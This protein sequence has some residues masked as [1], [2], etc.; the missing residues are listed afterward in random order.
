MNIGFDG[1]GTKVKIAQMANNHRTIA[2]D[3]IA[4]VA[5]DAV[6]RGAEP[7]LV[8]TV[9]DVNSLGTS[10]KPFIEEVRQLSEGYINAAREAN[11][12][13]INGEVAEIG[14]CVGG[15]GPFNYNWGAGV[16]WFARKD[17][18][19]TGMEIKEGDYLVGLREKGFRSNGLSLVRKVMEK[20][21]GEDWYK[22]LY[23][24]RNESLA[25]LVLTPSKIY[26]KAAVDM[27]GG[28]AGEPRTEVHGIVHVTGGGIP[29]K[30][31]R[32]LKPSEL[33]ATIDSSFEPPEIMEYTQKIGGVT[34]FEAYKTWNMGPG[35]IIVT[36]KPEEVIKIAEEYDIE[37]KKIG[38]VTKEKGIRIEN[39]GAFC[40]DKYSSEK[41]YTKG[42]RVLTF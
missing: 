38:Q 17:R 39:R 41:L 33:G 7:V 35:M 29:G 13:I 16:V 23:E 34:D 10:E 36:P 11:V 1:I 5:E 42:E 40:P 6:V 32:V 2:Y 18:M 20:V 22:V 12:V 28:Y 14:N 26:T 25:D 3:L 21:H 19:F 15:F 4:M 37:S 8:G 27:F 24:G 9:L 30:L 31:G